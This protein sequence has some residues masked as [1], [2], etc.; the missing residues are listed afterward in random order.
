MILAQLILRLRS[1]LNL[2]SVCHQHTSLLF[3]FRTL[4]IGGRHV[5]FFVGGARFYNY[6]LHVT[7]DFPTDWNGKAE[8]VRG[9]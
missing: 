8:I 3:E 9:W 4:F 7:T 5:F 1:D 2:C 6:S